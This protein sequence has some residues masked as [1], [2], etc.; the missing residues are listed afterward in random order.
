M[1]WSW[2]VHLRL[3]DV[4]CRG[5]TG[6]RPGPIMTVIS[7][8]EIVSNAKTVTKGLEALRYGTALPDVLDALLH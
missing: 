1:G 3:A 4:R 2:L 5:R 8:D 7:Q 6:R